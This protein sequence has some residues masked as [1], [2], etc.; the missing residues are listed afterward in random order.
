MFTIMTW[1]VENFFAPQPAEQGAYDAKTAA[2]AATIRDA[3]LDLVA[4]HQVGDP[5]SFE[6][7]RAQLGAG[8]WGELATHYEPSHAIRVGWLTQ[9]TLTDVQEVV[10]LPAKLSPVRVED[11]G[12]TISQ[13]GRGGPR[14]H[15]HRQ[16][17]PRGA[18]AHLP[19]EVETADLS[20]RSV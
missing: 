11:D 15:L 13:L 14:R 18:G 20:R 19:P 12:R 5:Q 9:S 3:A 17:R 10:A 6:A 4:L 7:L 16:L 1:N 8:W 2:L